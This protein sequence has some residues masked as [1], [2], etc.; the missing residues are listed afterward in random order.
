MWAFLRKG[1]PSKEEVT[2]SWESHW[3]QPPRKGNMKENVQRRTK[4]LRRRE[5]NSLLLEEAVEAA[6]RSH[7]TKMWHLSLK[8]NHDPRL[9]T[10]R[11]ASSRH[12]DLDSPETQKSQVPKNQP[13]P[14]KLAPFNRTFCGDGTVLFCAAQFG[15]HP[16]HVVNW[17]L[18]AM[19]AVQLGRW[20]L[21]LFN[22]N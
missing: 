11:N 21:I 3:V 13:L 15:R 8:G 20:I 14:S 12:P 17:A 22:F 10:A 6:S 1:G 19:W 7:W 16:P 4:V 9:R 2:G 5:E 18:T